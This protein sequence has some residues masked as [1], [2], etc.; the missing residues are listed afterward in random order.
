MSNFHVSFGLIYFSCLYRYKFNPEPETEEIPIVPKD[1]L[2]ADILSRCKKLIIG[3]HVHD[4]LLEDRPDQNLTEE[5]RNAAWMDFETEKDLEAQRE[6]ER[7]KQQQLR[8][9]QFREQQ[10]AHAA[11]LAQ[12]QQQQQQQQEFMQNGQNGGLLAD[13]LQRIPGLNN[14]FSQGTS[15]PQPQ[16]SP[17]PQAD[18]PRR[19]RPP[20]SVKFDPEKRVTLT[21]QQVILFVKTQYPTMEIAGQMLQIHAFIR[22]QLTSQEKRMRELQEKAHLFPDLAQRFEV[23]KQNMEGFNRLLL[24]YG[25]MQKSLAEN[26]KRVLQQQMEAMQK[27]EKERLD[28]ELD[29]PD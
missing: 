18:P 26:R 17:Q 10:A 20:G 16:A 25:E 11:F 6:Q 3:Y 7:L 2:F 28:A 12:Q 22:N 23:V 1:R 13:M 15:Q 9:Q 5:E 14:L 4:S 19:G 21:M 27:Q 29:E 24:E 8:E